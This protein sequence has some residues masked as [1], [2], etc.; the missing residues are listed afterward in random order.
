MLSIYIL[1]FL[2]SSNL[3]ALGEQQKKN[4]YS[5]E[6]RGLV[7]KY[8]LIDTAYEI[9]QVNTPSF[10]KYFNEETYNK[11]GE[12]TYNHYL[13]LKN[14]Y[15]KFTPEMKN[16]LN[17]IY[18]SDIHPWSLLNQVTQ[19]NDD[20]D[21]EKIIEQLEY[22]IFKKSKMRNAI[23]EFYPYFYNNFLKE[24]LEKN[25]PIFENYAKNTNEELQKNNIDLL[26]FMEKTSG[27]QF[28][29]KFKPI[30]YYTLRPIGAYGFTYNKKYKI[31]T[32]QR[33][34]DYKELLGSPFHEYSHSLFQTFTFTP[35][36]IKIAEKMKKDSVFVKNWGDYKNSYDWRG[37]CEENLVEG[38]ANY[39]DYKYYGTKKEK[40]IYVYDVEFFNYLINTN[41][42]PSKITL[43]DASINFYRGILAKKK[44]L[45]LVKMKS[46][47]T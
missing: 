41:F 7:L 1:L 46:N 8:V 25:T 47:I 19:L 39:L 37:W 21:L 3:Y 4:D 32:I 22:I 26:S 9:Y 40:Q 6:V 43:K 10:S 17:I 35:E 28:E 34:T 12:D 5:I 15:E 18:D 45:E 20:A 24:Y 11:M 27:I 36:F 38:F 31:S 44:L 23:K 29:E 2:C 42:D 13:W 16:N 33:E 30:F 14:T